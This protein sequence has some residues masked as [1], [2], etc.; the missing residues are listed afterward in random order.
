MST[1]ILLSTQWSELVTT[2]VCDYVQHV[3]VITQHIR[4]VQIGNDGPVTIWLD[5][6][7]LSTVR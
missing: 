7:E 1:A 4:D 2:K 6:D 3:V 5:T